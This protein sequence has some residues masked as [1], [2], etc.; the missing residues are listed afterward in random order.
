[1]GKLY[2]VLLPFLFFILIGTIGYSIYYSRIIDKTILSSDSNLLAYK[3]LPSY[4]FFAILPNS[5]EPYLKDLVMG[6]K[7]EASKDAVAL[8]IN[9]SN[10][11]NEYNDTIRLLNIAIDSRVNGIITKGYNTPEF[12]GLLGDAEKKNIPVVSLDPSSPQSEKVAYVG[13]NG[14]E[15]G[16]KEGN[17]V[18]QASWGN[19]KVAMVLEEGMDNYGNVKVE[20]FKDAIKDYKDIKIITTKI[21]ETGILGAHNIT[22]EIL[23]NFPEVNTIVCTTSK[24]TI[25]VAQLIVDF[26][27]V[28]DVAIIGY[29]SSPEILSYIQK[30]II[31]GTIVPN[32]HA[33]GTKSIKFLMDVKKNGRASNSIDADSVVVTKQNV[34]E[35]IKKIASERGKT[36]K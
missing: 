19:A 16:Y 33:I 28:G 15:M 1:M 24:D 6:L 5:D 29:D 17:L 21:S 30:G 3:K 35:Y 34:N 10:N 32:F 26:N 12:N 36:D 20:G 2:K 8:E 31:F 25:G 4:H 18:V 23:N 9:Y 22:Q 11:V 14:F 13:T 7:E 27:R